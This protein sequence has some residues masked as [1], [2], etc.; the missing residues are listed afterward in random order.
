MGPENGSGKHPFDAV[1]SAKKWPYF[2]RPVRGPKNDAENGRIRSWSWAK[3]P[4]KNG[5]PGNA[6]M[7]RRPAGRPADEL[8]VVF[9]P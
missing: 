3:N 2:E 1:R 6:E 8:L 9:S 5:P 4:P 7:M